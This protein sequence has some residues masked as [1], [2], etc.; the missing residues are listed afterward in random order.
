MTT[1]EI[2]ER[3]TTDI[4]ISIMEECGSPV[5]GR[6][7]TSDGVPYLVFLTMCHHSDPDEASPKLYFYEESKDFMCYTNCGRMTFF[8]AI[9]KIKGLSSFKDVLIYIADKLDI[10][11]YE[12]S[13]RKK[14]E[15]VYNKD[16]DNILAEF[17][18]SIKIESSTN[19]IV[20]DISKD[21]YFDNPEDLNLLK[22]FE[23]RP[24][25]GWIEE[26]I[27]PETMHK[28]QILWDGVMTRVIIPHFIIGKDKQK[29]MVGIKR[30]SLTPEDLHEAKY[31]PI[32][33]NGKLYAHN[34]RKMF[35]GLYLTEEKIKSSKEITIVEAE[36]S[37]LL[38]DT[39]YGDDSTA[40]AVN[41]FNIYPWHIQKMRELEVNTIYLA[42]DKDVDLYKD[43]SKDAKN[44]AK[45]LCSIIR[46]L[47]RQFKVKV[48]YDKWNKLDLKDSPFD[49]GKDTFEFL[50][51]RAFDGED[52][53]RL[54][55]VN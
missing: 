15:G 16:C 26:G 6:G 33:V 51:S 32:T 41:G 35:Y 11:L 5:M 37:V 21:K 9:M 45:K 31:K 24:Y 22:Y 23:D 4:V 49:K 3:V 53:V 44:Y 52:F 50:K 29:H 8:D 2:L 36:K 55:D 42:F 20:E 7:Y 27:S 47:S 14:I 40:V 18:N 48:I 17:N 25:E 39:Y 19:D 46:K 38:S 30:R 54:W 10:D 43:K 34:V 1:K 28:Y 12:D 13:P